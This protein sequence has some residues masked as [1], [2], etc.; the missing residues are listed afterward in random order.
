LGGEQNN[1]FGGGAIALQAPPSGYV[2]GI[3]VTLSPVFVASCW[4][5]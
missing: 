5:K 1:F 3:K 2:H 4:K